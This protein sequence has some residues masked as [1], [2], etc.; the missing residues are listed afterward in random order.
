MGKI[1]LVACDPESRGRYLGSKPI[2]ANYMGDFSL[3]G[4]IVDRLPEACALLARAGY[5]VEKGDGGADIA[6]ESVERLA[7]IP[8][9]LARDRIACQFADVADTLYQA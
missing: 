2:P 1:A 3:T 5:Q 7:A 4:F 8:S 9:L 6:F